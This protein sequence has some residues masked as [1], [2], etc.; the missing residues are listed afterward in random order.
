MPNAGRIIVLHTTGPPSFIADSSGVMVG[1]RLDTRRGDILKGIIEG[2][3][4]Y[5]KECVDSLPSTGIAITDFRAVGGG[6]KSDAWVQTSAD[7]MGHPFTRPAITEAGALGAAIIAGVGCG[8]FSSY[9]EG[10]G[11]MVRLERVFEPDQQRREQYMENYAKYR[12][13]WPLMAGYLRGVSHG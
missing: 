13:L 3:T 1:M 11:A 7:I 5:L 10:V 2:A 6:S 4:Y 8:M 9:T 12:Q